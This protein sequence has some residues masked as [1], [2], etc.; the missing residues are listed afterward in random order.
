MEILHVLLCEFCELLC[1]NLEKPL[2]MLCYLM[3]AKTDII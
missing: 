3:D 1:L 2:E